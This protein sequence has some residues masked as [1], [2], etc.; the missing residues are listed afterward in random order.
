MRRTR[1]RLRRLA[2]RDEED[3]KEEEAG[4]TT[5]DDERKED[6]PSKR[7]SLS[8]WSCPA[9]TLHN[10]ATDE[11]CGLCGHGRD[12]EEQAA[13]PVS[14][15]RPLSLHQ[16]SRSPRPVSTSVPSVSTRL[17]ESLDGGCGGSGRD[18]G[19]VLLPADAAGCGPSSDWCSVYRPLSLSHLAVHTRKVQDVRRWLEHNTDTDMTYP[20][21]ASHATQPRTVQPPRPRQTVLLLTGPP[22]SGKMT[23]VGRVL[24]WR[25]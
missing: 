11:R 3:Q 6:E 13:P 17:S 22:G 25:Q 5:V 12:R 16:L 2:A 8:H 24:G 21:S 9:C 7:R 20:H 10:S 23:M 1:Q 15:T 18:S 4:Q 14:R 19:E